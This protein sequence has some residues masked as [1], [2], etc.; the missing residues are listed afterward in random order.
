MKVKD[1][2]V[3]DFKTKTSKQTEGTDRGR[4]FHNE[5]LYGIPC[6]CVKDSTKKRRCAGEAESPRSCWRDIEANSHT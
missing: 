5:L 3:D 4:P 2:R 1:A 6:Q